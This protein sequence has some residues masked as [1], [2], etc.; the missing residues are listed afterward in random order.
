MKRSETNPLARVW[1]GSNRGSD[2][3][4]FA[5]FGAGA[6]GTAIAMVLAEGAEHKVSLWSARPEHA[7]LLH[8]KRE[9]VR[10]RPGVPIPEAVLL[11]A[12]I[13]EAVAQA[14]LIVTAIPTVHLRHTLA[15]I[16]PSV[17]ASTPVLSL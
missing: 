15:R 1:R 17:P 6:W 10:L 5:I 13:R 3:T 11:T 12:D 9:N 7:A 16:A 2:M 8:Q 14:D 4:H